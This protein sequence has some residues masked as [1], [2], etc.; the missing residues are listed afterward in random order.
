MNKIFAFTYIVLFWCFMPGCT[1]DKKE[2]P[3][4]ETIYLNYKKLNLYYGDEVQLT[5]S[6]TSGLYQ[7]ES[8]NNAI[9]S[10]SQSGALKA[11]GKGSTYIT[12]T[13]ENG[14]VKELPV[15]VTVPSADKV[16][17]RPGA[18]R[19]AVV[20]DIRSEL[21]KEVKITRMD[22]NESQIAN[23]GF[24][25][26]VTTVYYSGLDEGSYQFSVVCLDKYGMESDPVELNISVYGSDYENSIKGRRY[27]KEHLHAFGNG[28]FINWEDSGTGEAIEFTY[29]N[30]VGNEVKELVESHNSY[31]ILYDYATHPLTDLSYV[32]IMRPSGSIDDFRSQPTIIPV[33]DIKDEVFVLKTTGVEKKGAL[34]ERLGC[35]HFDIGGEGIG[36]H[37]NG[38][39]D[40][41][42]QYPRQKLYGD[43]MSNFVDF[44]GGGGNGTDESANLGYNDNGE[45]HAFTVYVED[46]GNYAIDPR[47]GLNDASTKGVISVDGQEWAFSMTGWGGGWG[48]YKYYFAEAGGWE[49]VPTFNLTHGFHKIVYRWASGGYN[50]QGLKITYKP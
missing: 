15:A 14:V 11:T 17:G 38:T 22:T 13:N 10:I 1:G 42:K 37:D 35:L 39:T 29:I 28:L 41:N 50:Y 7:W 12:V 45:W 9:A 24:Q 2:F 46:A 40:G 16:T 19:A 26:G 23:I 44:E 6:P 34:V 21:I 20:L 30:R 8:G 18:Y 5:I 48:S 31:L 43:Y 36:F 27:N 4:D 25:A 32:T 33:A 47:V 3:V 49:N